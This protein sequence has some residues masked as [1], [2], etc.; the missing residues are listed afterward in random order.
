MNVMGYAVCT[1]MIAQSEGG[2]D[3]KA[4]ERELERGSVVC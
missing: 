2:L 3:R 4:L 1:L